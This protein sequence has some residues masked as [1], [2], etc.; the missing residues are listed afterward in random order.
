DVAGMEAAIVSA[1]THSEDEVLFAL[2]GVPDQPGSAAAILEAVAANQVSVDTILQNVARGP[3]EISFSVPQEDVSATRRALARAQ[4]ALGAIEV[5]EISDLGKVSLVG[6][7]M[8]SN[9]GVAAR[10]FRT[11]ADEDINLRLV[12]TSPIKITCLVARANVERAVR[13]LH[14]TFLERS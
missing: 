1:V 12:S 2:R 5:E 9:P 8:R 4:E 7:G 14:E 11:L 10:M 3:A 13:A 6:A